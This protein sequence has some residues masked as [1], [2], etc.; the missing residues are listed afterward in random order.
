MLDSGHVRA[1]HILVTRAFAAVD[2]L[3]SMKLLS[4]LRKV[5]H[6]TRLRGRACVARGDAGVY[7]ELV[8]A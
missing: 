3:S 1:H 6:L 7:V 5:N 8:S 4:V 2:G